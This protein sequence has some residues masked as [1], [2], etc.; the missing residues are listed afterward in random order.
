MASP[1]ISIITPSFDQAAYLE[2]TISSVIGQNY[3]RLFYHV[4]D[5]GS[6]DNTVE[7]LKSYGD[8]ISWRSAPDN[9]Q[10]DAINAGFAQADCDIMAY[11]NSDDTLL[12]GTLAFGPYLPSQ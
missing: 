9:G 4:Q 10:S 2:Q 6:N 11:L 8:K 12:P 5:G 3:P 7:I 1:R